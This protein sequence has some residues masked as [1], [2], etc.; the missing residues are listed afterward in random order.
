VL[1]TSEFIVTV[2]VNGMELN[3][4]YICFNMILI[5]LGKCYRQS[6]QC[7]QC[8]NQIDGPSCGE[9]SKIIPLQECQTFCYFAIIRNYTIYRRKRLHTTRAIRDCSNYSDIEIESEKILEIKIPNIRHHRSLNIMTVKR[10]IG[11]QCNN[12]FYLKESNGGSL[13]TKITSR[14]CYYLIIISF[15]IILFYLNR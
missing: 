15:V 14:H 12:E 10:C 7:L 11:E 9:F 4:F 13:T 3:L 8:D 5:Q 1:F 6:F 2:I